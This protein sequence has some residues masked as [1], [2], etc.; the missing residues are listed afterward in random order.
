MGVIKLNPKS[1][2]IKQNGVQVDSTTRRMRAGEK[3]DVP[4]LLVTEDIQLVLLKVTLALGFFIGVTAWIT[5]VKLS[6][7]AVFCAAMYMAYNALLLRR[8]K[9]PGVNEFL[10]NLVLIG[11]LDYLQ[12]SYCP[13]LYHILLLRMT[14]K[15][16]GKRS[17]RVAMMIASVFLIS[18]VITGTAL[19]ID[20][21]LDTVFN[22]WVTMMV[23]YAVISVHKLIAKQNRDDSQ[24]LEL[25]KQNEHNYQMALTD[26]LT[27]L[28]NHRAYK[29]KINTLDRYILLIID[30]D[31]FKKLNDTYGHLMGDK[32]LTL[33]GNILKLSIR[34]GD[35]AF[36]YGGEEFV[37]VL[38]GTSYTTGYQIAERL[39]MQISECTLKTSEGVIPITVSIGMAVKT[40]TMGSQEAFEK[41]D[42]ALY[43]AKQSGR[44]NVQAI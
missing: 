39:R 25:I 4:N 42:R 38:P 17:G 6:S 35:M 43:I 26:G 13:A 2:L 33:I 21:A 14:L 44:N 32:V 36:R 9:P 27:G 31:C 28:Y 34:A 19:T 23:T 37:V 16:G 1:M 18:R 24:M 12:V 5:A 11:I 29:E 7:L 22:L 41:A 15:A 3:P 30:I 20:G 40:V 8:C 10:I